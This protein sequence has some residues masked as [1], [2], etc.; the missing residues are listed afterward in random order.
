MSFQQLFR[1]QR[2]ATSRKTTSPLP[3]KKKALFEQQPST[4]H[5]LF[6]SNNK[7]ELSMA[8]TSAGT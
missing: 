1:H 4:L 5:G 3:A 7:E 2:H 8:C 6:S